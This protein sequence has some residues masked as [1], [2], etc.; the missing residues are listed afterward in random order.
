M[1]PQKLYELMLSR[2]DSAWPPTQQP[3]GR[4]WSEDTLIIDT[5]WD[6][7]IGTKTGNPGSWKKL[8]G[9][10]AASNFPPENLTSQIDGS[11]DTLKNHL[12]K[13]FL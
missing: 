12:I 13:V 9:A 10:G 4:V 3:V 8:S 5:N 11:K 6:L 7:W 1:S 2:F